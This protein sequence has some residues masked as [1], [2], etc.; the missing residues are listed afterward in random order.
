MPS[1]PACNDF[2]LFLDMHYNHL[3][4][5]YFL[6]A[7]HQGPLAGA[8]HCGE[9]GSERQGTWVRFELQCD[10][11]R[12]RSAAFNAFACPH[13]IA[14]CAR[15]CEQAQGLALPLGALPGGVEALRRLFELP[16][17][18]LGRLLLV[19][20]AWRNVAQAA[21]STAQQG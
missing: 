16:A 17:E 1:R 8:T 12:V 2:A 15:V 21:N 4:L 9:A 5:K 13:V 6:S 19:E 14:I 10:A 20:D 7:P 11:T 18:K 3:T